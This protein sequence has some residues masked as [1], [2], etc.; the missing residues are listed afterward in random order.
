MIFHCGPE[1]ILESHI[2]ALFATDRQFAD[3]YSME[4]L[5]SRVPQYVD[6][7]RFGG[8][9]TLGVPAFK[10]NLTS[11]RPNFFVTLPFVVGERPLLFDNDRLRENIL[12]LQSGLRQPRFRKAKSL[13]IVL[14]KEDDPEGLLVSAFRNSFLELKLPVNFYLG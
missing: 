6:L 1:A 2:L 12:L 13:G 10:Q 4:F 8:K 5:Y 14:L 11:F 3:C 7:F 9:F